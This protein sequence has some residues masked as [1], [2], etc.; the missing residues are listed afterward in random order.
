M[1][2]EVVPAIA[3]A[4]GGGV[5]LGAI[6]AYERTRDRQMRS[7]RDTYEATF[8]V[9]TDAKDAVAALRSLAGLDFGYELVAEVAADGDGIHHLLH[10][11]ERVAGSVIDQLSGAIRGLRLDPVEARSTG[12]VTIGWRIVVPMRAL[13]RSEEA[14]HASQA[15]L[16]GLAALRDDERLSLRWALRPSSGSIAMPATRHD[17]TSLK[18]KL[19]QRAWQA[20]AG[21]QG[22]LV[23]GLLLV[24]A[25]TASRAREL[26]E[27]VISVLRSRHGVTTGVIVRR[28]R[29]RSG[30]VLPTTGRTRGWLSAPEL[31]PLLGWPLGRE[32]VEGV[33]HGAARRLAAPRELPREG[34]QLLVGRDAYGDRPVALTPDAARHHVAIVGPSGTGKSVLLARSVLADL[35]AGYGGVVID[36]KG[37]LVTDL[38]DR[39]PRSEAERVVV[40]DPAVRGPVAGL[41]VFG[42]G[43]PDLRS[44]VILGVLAA[45]FKDSWGIRSDTYLRLGLRTLS[46]LPQPVLA[47]WPRLFTD[48]S[49]RHDAVQ[50]LNDPVVQTAW[51]SWEALSDAE[52]YQHVA[53]PMSKVMSLL[54]RPAL[55][56]VLAQ[57]QPRLDVARLLREGKWLLVALSPGTLGEPAARLLGAVV[58]YLVW[59]AVEAR[60]GLPAR[61][62]DPVFLYFDEL[63]SLAS[64]PFGIEYLFERA[65][66]LGSGITVATQAFGRL[67]DSVRQALLG[68]VGSLIS[69]RLGYDEATR[70]ARELPRLDAQDLQA[71]REF[72]VAARLST[73][74]GSGVTVVTGHT[75]PLPPR[76]GQAD[77]IRSRSAERYGVDPAEVDA[78]LQRSQQGQAAGAVGRTRRSS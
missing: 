29:V 42:S 36:P 53:A 11:P 33:M 20:R 44:D 51:A 64:L 67:P 38:L 1:R 27:H 8:P 32:P 17:P 47:D 30:S 7:S 60:S 58:T 71:L 73:G 28:A 10:L 59:T 52:R 21:D 54:S 63:Q 49:F 46:E 56:A 13:L 50:R 25:G 76:E 62:R 14:E 9:A 40:L 61:Q 43:D 35:R 34:R 6:A 31:L 65:R 78:Q 55:R 74:T 70:L 2:G 45:I 26:G 22:F 3:A 5:M 19:E 39:I 77:H 23:A 24:R 66:G 48:A 16:S 15:L 69:F 57:P 68:N 75:D 37:D 72:E 12:T 4:G 18:V 41:D